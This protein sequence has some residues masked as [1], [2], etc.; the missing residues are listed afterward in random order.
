MSALDEILENI[1]LTD[2]LDYEA[3]DWKKGSSGQAQVRIC[4]SCGDSRSLNAK[5][6]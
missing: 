6:K 4:P 2:W 5:G 3:I 1:E